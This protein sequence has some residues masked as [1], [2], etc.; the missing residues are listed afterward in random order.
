MMASA[1]TFVGLKATYAYFVMLLAHREAELM[2][3]KK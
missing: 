3:A 2:E 1:S